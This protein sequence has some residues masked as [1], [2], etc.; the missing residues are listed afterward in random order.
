MHGRRHG[1][2][3][4]GIGPEVVRDLMRPRPPGSESASEFGGYQ[5]IW[6]DPERR[7]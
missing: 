3:E 6:I 1:F 7:C 4:S 2:L 5:G